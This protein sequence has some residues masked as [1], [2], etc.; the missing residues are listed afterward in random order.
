MYS[1]MTA[2]LRG[3]ITLIFFA[4]NFQGGGES[5][6]MLW[7]FVQLWGLD[8]A[9]FLKIRVIIGVYERENSRI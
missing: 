2:S 5:V 3:Y 9:F 8:G 1:D 6:E 7:E 4:Q